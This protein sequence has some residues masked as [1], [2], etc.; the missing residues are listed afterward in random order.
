[1]KPFVASAAI[2]LIVLTLAA[3]ISCGP[4][5]PTA[6]MLHIERIDAWEEWRPS[7][8]EIAKGGTVTWKN[9]SIVPLTHSV[10]SLDGLFDADVDPGTSFSYT[11]TENGT[12]KYH[13]MLNVAGITEDFVGTIYV[14]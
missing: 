5:I 4:K 8:V 3:G 11:F 14:R 6:A 13:D 10:V 7:T 1:M 2:S 9:T 12:F